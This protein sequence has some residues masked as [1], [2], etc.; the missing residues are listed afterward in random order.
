MTP[1]STSLNHSCFTNI[2]KYLIQPSPCAAAR[3]ENSWH[4][5]TR[6]LLLLA[7]AIAAL[8]F[9]MFSAAQAASD[10]PHTGLFNP[11]AAAFNPVTGKG[12]TVNTAEGVIH[13]SD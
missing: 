10:V 2:M 11:A 5:R 1:C 12:Y 4:G 9:S 6:A 13:I 7:A 8:G 3:H